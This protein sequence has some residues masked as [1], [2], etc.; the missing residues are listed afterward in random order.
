MYRIIKARSIIVGG[1]FFIMVFIS[2]LLW[3]FGRIGGLAD[4]FIFNR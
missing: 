3:A 4:A 2:G 1:T